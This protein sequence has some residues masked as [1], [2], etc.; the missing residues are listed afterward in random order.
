MVCCR[1]QKYSSNPKEILFSSDTSGNIRAFG[2]SGRTPVLIDS[3]ANQ[4]GGEIHSFQIHQTFLYFCEPGGNLKILNFKN[5]RKFALF[6][7]FNSFKVGCF[8]VDKTFCVSSKG[9]QVFIQSHPDK[10][11]YLK[12]DKKKSKIAVLLTNNLKN[13]TNSSAYALKRE[14]A[15]FGSDQGVSSLLN[16]KSNKII[17]QMS[18]PNGGIHH[19]CC[20][21][22]REDFLLIGY[23]NGFLVHFCLQTMSLL[24][25]FKLNTEI[26]TVTLGRFDRFCYVGTW[27]N[28]RFFEIQLDTQV[29]PFKAHLFLSLIHI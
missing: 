23:E 24:H 13:E 1:I 27:E 4:K 12:I 22:R 3:Y 10:D 28:K 19:S 8:F 14:L 20:F 25:E 15:Y 6:K 29:S 16:S 11:N 18:I 2:I 7:S 21:S 5:K 9:S 17:H 26:L